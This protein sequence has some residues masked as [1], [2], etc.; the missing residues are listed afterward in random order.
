MPPPRK[1][2][3]TIDFSKH[4]DAVVEM[5]K[6]LAE[7]FKA[8]LIL[9]HSVNFP[10]DTLHN[11]DAHERVGKRRKMTRDAEARLQTML[12]DAPV[13]PE[14]LVAWGD[15]VEALER[16]VAETGTDFVVAA[17]HGLSG[18]QRILMGTVIERVVRKISCPIMVLQPNRGGCA[19]AAPDRIRCLVAACGPNL[20]PDEIPLFAWDM[21]LRFQ[22]RLHLVHALERPVDEDILDPTA[23][24]YAQVQEEL[25]RRIRWRLMDALSDVARHLDAVEAAVEP[26]APNEVLIEYARRHEADLVVVGVRRHGAVHK[27]FVGS[28][29]DALLRKAPCAVLTIPVS[30]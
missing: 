29:T 2:L 7:G 30:A 17:S 13:N 28:T 22:A 6:R 19:V 21:A 27:S 10:R 8:R 26:G 18:F 12:D 23:G 4:T 9:F 25:R 1:I 15:P 24:P 20:Q 3:C 14:V 11:S 5:G 16:A